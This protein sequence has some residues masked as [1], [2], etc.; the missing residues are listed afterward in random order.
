MSCAVPVDVDS[1]DSNDDDED[2]FEDTRMSFASTARPSTEIRLSSASM[3]EY[4]LWMAE[5]MSIKERRKRLLQGMGLS[6]DKE[7]LRL[8]SV[9]LRQPDSPKS[10]SAPAPPPPPAAAPAAAEAQKA[11]APPAKNDPLPSSLPLVP[12]ATI[13]RVRSDGPAIASVAETDAKGRR[14]QFLGPPPH[15]TLARALSAPSSL[16]DNRPHSISGR[17]GAD[18]SLLQDNESVFCTIKN[19]DTGK[20]FVIKEFKEDGMLNRLS[21][22]ETGRQLTMEEFEKSVGF[23][24]IVKEVMRRVTVDGLMNMKVIPPSISKSIK[25]SKKKGGSWLKNI[26]GVTAIKGVTNSIS[27]LKGEL[28]KVKDR[29]NSVDGAGRQPSS[30]RMKVRQQGKPFKEL[31][32]LYMSQEIQAHEGSIWTIR[33]SL[34][35]RYLASAGE[36]RVIHIWEVVE[37]PGNDEGIMNL[38]RPVDNGSLD[39]P[40]PLPARPPCDK[41]KKGKLSSSVRKSSSTPENIIVPNTVF[42]LSETPVCSFQGH[43]DDVLDLSWSKSQHLLSSSMDKTVRLWDMETKTCLK[44]FAHNDYVTCIQFN[45]IDD[46]YF[47][48]GSLDAKVRIWSIPDRQVVD[49]SDLHEM[50]TAACYTPDG[51][52]AVVGSHK[53]TCR[54][55]NTSDF[56][57]LQKDQVDIQTKKKK[58]N[59]KKITGFQFAPENPSEVLITSADSQIRVFDGLDLIHKFKGFKNTS[60]QIA[61]SFTADGRYVVSASEDSQVYVWRRDEV[62]NVGGSKRGKGMV[63]T[64]SHEHFQCRDVSVAIPWPGG[65]GKYE[66]PQLQ[67]ESTRQNN[68]QPPQ[69]PKPPNPT[70]ASDGPIVVEDEPTSS[71]NSSKKNQ[72][73]PP[74]KKSVSEQTGPSQEEEQGSH[75]RS[76][77]DSVVPFS[78]S[79]LYSKSGLLSSISASMVS[80]MPSSWLWYDANSTGSQEATAWGLVIVTAGLGGEIKTYQNFGLPLRLTR[81]PSLF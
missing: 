45:P 23:S 35:S 43:L 24:P 28:E 78:S 5:P 61:A 79:S 14:E 29:E 1:S 58:A 70:P 65:I 67:S 34:D 74:P 50:V 12:S 66:L 38:L 20:E 25:S 54:W 18:G 41:K 42:S 55:Y 17:R 80:S 62:L 6:A 21:D 48:S 3:A 77:S 57:L 49:W 11:P 22:T 46:R 7:F 2:D 30:R 59:A 37:I 16:C 68:D 27:G 36:D 63:T 32:G 9:D 71:K 44:L 53:G 26:K 15:L 33:F 47:I 76:R 4:K 73:P 69:Q 40:A 81:Q 75:S 31:T 13:A 8:T 51:Q 10:G 60:S 64:R 52:G 19:L 72:C 39:Q 56:K